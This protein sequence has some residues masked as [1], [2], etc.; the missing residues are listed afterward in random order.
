MTGFGDSLVKP[1]TGA[2][3][4]GDYYALMKPR[5][6]QLVVFTAL[7]GMV[8]APSG[9]HPVLALASLAC[10]AA[11]AGAAGALNMWWDADIDAE[12]SRTSARPVP[13]GKVA[14][15]EALGIGLGLSILS[16]TLLGVFSNLLAAGLMAFTIVFYAV[17]YSM[18]L[19]RST[20]HN[21]VIGGAAGA[22]PPMIAWTAMTGEVSTAPVLMF[23]VIFLWTPPHFWALA[24]FRNDD[25]ARAG[26]PMM[27]VVAG[28]PATR[29]QIWLYTLALV[30]A[31]LALAFTSAGGPITLAAGLCANALM[32]R[33]A[34]AA[35]WG[36]AARREG[37]D[38][39]R[40]EKK[41]FGA[42]IVYLFVVFGAVVADAAL[43]LA[44]GPFWPQWI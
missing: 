23:A 7:A 18:W 16:V 20:P 8:A 10:I 26:V 17:V 30:P 6:M 37:G 4:P 3:E 29:R 43:R 39:F 13:S 11:G 1:R 15:G 9:P 25:Y 33:R 2:A 19:K 14:G 22:L 28:K 12:M 5:V 24:L 42:S 44:T 41:L 31:P 38:G 32:L 21:I 34:W 40:A 35:C 36:E 27:P